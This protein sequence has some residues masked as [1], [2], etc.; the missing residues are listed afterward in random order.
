[1]YVDLEYEARTNGE[2]RHRLN[3]LLCEIERCYDPAQRDSSNFSRYQEALA[4]F[5][6]F[7]NFNSVFLTPH[8][9]PR[10]LRD[11]PLNFADFPFAW[12]MFAI[13]L[14]GFMVFR[15]SRQISKS[16]SFCCRQLEGRDW[17]S[18]LLLE[19]ALASG[20]RRFIT[21][22]GPGITPPVEL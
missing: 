15:G 6:K 11:E 9:W 18:R 16:T 1:M 21:S 8:F 19:A 4:A 14:G 20:Q 3:Q 17:E 2:F 7:C 5:V 22:T 13:Q 12:P 10:Y